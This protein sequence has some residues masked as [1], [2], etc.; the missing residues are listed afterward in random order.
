MF[1]L[2]MPSIAQTNFLRERTDSIVISALPKRNHDAP[3]AS[4]D[5]KA[6]PTKQTAVKGKAAIVVQAPKKQA[7]G[8]VAAA[9]P[10]KD[11]KKKV[12]A[13]APAKPNK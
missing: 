6:S 4:S 12:A 1:Y 7:P 11:E 5:R 2:R 13:K 9:P 3:A 8:K 10:K